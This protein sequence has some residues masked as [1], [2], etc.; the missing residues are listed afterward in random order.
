MQN[1]SIHR[2]SELPHSLK[3]EVEQLLGRTIAPDEEVS[4]ASIPPQSSP[5]RGSRDE[6]VPS[7]EAFL[8]SRAQRVNVLPD[9]EIDMAIDEAVHQ[10]RH[11]R[12]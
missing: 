12:P 9:E 3:A 8:D 5:D 11:E 10:L 2:A 1:I 7:F 4:V 6:F